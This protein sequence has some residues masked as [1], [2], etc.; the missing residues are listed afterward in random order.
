MP[1]FFKATHKPEI[2]KLLLDRGANPQLGTK[3]DG[4]TKGSIFV[5]ALVAGN[6]RTLD[7]LLNR[8]SFKESWA[9]PRPVMSFLEAAAHGGVSTMKYLLQPNF[10]YPARGGSF[11]FFDALSVVLAKADWA[12]LALLFQRQLIGN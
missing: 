8:F 5:Q 6:I 2:L 12:S 10:R 1:V 7:L 11:E 4:P 9:N 3:T